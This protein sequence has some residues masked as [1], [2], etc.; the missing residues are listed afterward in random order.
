MAN[1]KSIPFQC[2]MCYETIQITPA[3]IGEEEV[4]LTLLQ[5]VAVTKPFSRTF[6]QYMYKHCRTVQDE[7]D[8]KLIYKKHKVPDK[9]LTKEFKEAI[10]KTKLNELFD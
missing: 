2:P 10:Q 4:S 6:K 8:G 9:V 3:H 1:I 5:D 7:P